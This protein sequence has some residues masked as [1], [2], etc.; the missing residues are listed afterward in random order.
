MA[1]KDPTKQLSNNN[2]FIVLLLLTLLVLGGAV[3]GGKLL[4]TDIIRDTKVKDAKNTANKQLDK[5]LTAAPQLV[6]RYDNL[7]ARKNLIAEALPNTSDLPGLIA[8]MENLSGS[9]GVSLKSVTPSQTATS[10]VASTT[11]P[12]E[13]ASTTPA[14]TSGASKPMPQP[15]AVSLTFDAT[16]PTLQK[17]LEAIEQ[18][19]RPMRVT[20]V[21]LTGSGSS[22]AVTLD[23]TTYYQD[24][25]DLPF[26]TKVIK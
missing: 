7:G 25:A 1:T 21:Q 2:Y 24:K 20:S 22:L 8:L 18:S 3:L 6:D 17:L 19:A 10:G 26:N 4:V 23:L 16:Y 14:A 12:A 9:S 11:A 13:T 5:N 15:Y